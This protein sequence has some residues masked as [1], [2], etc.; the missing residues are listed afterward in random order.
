MEF[1]LFTDLIKSLGQVFDGVQK[2]TKFSKEQRDSYYEVEMYEV[3]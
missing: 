3:I 2:V 1:T